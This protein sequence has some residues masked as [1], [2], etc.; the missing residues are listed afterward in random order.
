MN[1]RMKVLKPTV[2]ANVCVWHMC[3]PCLQGSLAELPVPLTPIHWAGVST[4]RAL[5]QLYCLIT[6]SDK[7][8]PYSLPVFIAID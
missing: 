7:Y 1:K 4:G 8:R 3:Q 6:V 2:N 5:L